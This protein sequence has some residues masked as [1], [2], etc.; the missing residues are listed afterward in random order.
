MIA[1]APAADAPYPFCMPILIGIAGGSASG[2]ST[3]AHGLVHALGPDRA[4]WLLQDSYYKE[5]TGQS[6]EQRALNNFDHPAAF[7]SE[8]LCLHLDSLLTGKAIEIPEYDYCT[9]LRKPQGTR[10]QSRE[11]I[12]LDG[13]MVLHEADLRARMSLKVFVE[14]PPEVRLQRRI[15]RDVALRDRTEPEVIRQFTTQVEPM[16]QQFVEPSKAYADIVIR[17][18]EEM[19]GAVGRVAEQIATLA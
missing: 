3:L 2:K 16:H 14:C 10:V 18:G 17:H 19:Q 4:Y 7:E 1:A 12:L 11:I 15:E 9:H 8:L 5:L 6:L 13:I